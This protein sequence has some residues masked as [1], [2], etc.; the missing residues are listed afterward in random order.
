LGSAI[1]KIITIPAALQ[2]VS[3][4]VPRIAHPDWL[5]KKMM[6]KSDVFKQRRI[7]EMFS[8]A[9]KK[10]LTGPVD[11]E[12]IGGGTPSKIQPS[13]TSAK[14]KREEEKRKEVEDLTKS[15][16]EVL[17][18]PPSM[19]KTKPE[20]REWLAFHKRKWAFQS[21]Q[22]RDRTKRRR[23]EDSQGGA[24]VVRTGMG[25]IGGFLRKTARSMFDLPW[26]IIQLCAAN[27]SLFIR[28]CFVFQLVETQIV[29]TVGSDRERSSHGQVASAENL[30]RQ[31]EITQRRSRRQK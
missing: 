8:S 6:E 4:P 27:I 25:G 12:D 22:R 30:L 16:K 28:C 2:S 15:W 19:G 21:K 9:P 20:I 31:S 1:Q 14:R 17:G 3:N 10:A 24:G 13:M 11:I 18:N 5:H 23:K 29:S 26:Q 7:N